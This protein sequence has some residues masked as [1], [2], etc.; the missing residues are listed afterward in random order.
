MAWLGDGGVAGIVVDRARYLSAFNAA[1]SAALEH[2]GP[3]RRGPRPTSGVA[4]K[5]PRTRSGALSRAEDYGVDLGL[6]REGL[7]LSR[8]ERL[9]ALDANA[10][11]LRAMRKTA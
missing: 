7:K 4:P 9:S 6:L 3:R 5:S 11:F 2:G 8:A 1:L 10:E